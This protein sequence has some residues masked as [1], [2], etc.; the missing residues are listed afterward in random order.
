LLLP[1]IVLL[2]FKHQFF[3]KAAPNL[4]DLGEN[5][6]EETLQHMVSKYTNTD[7]KQQSN[8]TAFTASTRAYKTEVQILELKQ[9]PNILL[10]QLS[11]PAT[12]TDIIDS[13]DDEDLPAYD[14]SNDTIVSKE[15]CPTYLID[16]KNGL[17][18][19]ENPELFEMSVQ[20]AEDLI[21]QQLPNNDSKIAI[22]LLR[23]FLFLEQKCYME[24]FDEK[25]LRSAIAICSV[26]PKAATEYLCQEFHSESTKYSVYKR[27]LMLEILGE[28]ARQ[29][30]KLDA[31]Q[32]AETVPK[33][34]PVTVKKLLGPSDDNIRQNT[35]RRLLRARIER[36]TRR[37]ATKTR[38]PLQ[39]GV[40]NRFAEV[41]GYFF[42]PLLHGFGK[43]QFIFTTKN[44]FKC[45]TDN[46]LLIHFLQTIA[47]IM[48]S[49]ENCLLAPKFAR[50]ILSL[51]QLLR[52]SAEPR[53]R[54][55]V[56]QMISAIFLAVPKSLLQTEFSGELME[57]KLWLEG[58]IENVVI[59][60]EP[61]EECRQMAHHLLVMCVNT[62]VMD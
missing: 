50:E 60:N 30:S 48:L 27:V 36:K 40:R 49:A 14:L 24:N 47:H 8:S 46:L 3:S 45:D 52:Y 55:G 33:S 44:N 35:A 54:L 6:V 51:S 21:W 41:A 18:V 29:L 25:I 37:F 38:N 11:G 26:H 10:Q 56:L 34:E 57:L 43:Q 12:L 32:V 53:V 28:T 16:L 19:D 39:G 15:K 4:P 9:T 13:D 17:L 2:D 61:N 22:E 20:A 58:C 23:I 59:N 31:K 7:N 62:L 42:F 5:Y 1:K